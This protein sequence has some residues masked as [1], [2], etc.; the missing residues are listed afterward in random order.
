MS[1]G[2]SFARNQ[3]LDSVRLFCNLLVVVFHA[4]PFLYF[5]SHSS[6][7]W[8]VMKF[9]VYYLGNVFL[10][11][12]FLVSGWLYFRNFDI[13][14]Y[15]DKLKARVKRL[16]V[17]YV[18]WNVIMIGVYWGMS[19]LSARSQWRF[20][21]FHLDSGWDCLMAVLPVTSFS[22]DAPTWFIRTLLIFAV[23]SPVIYC[24]FKYCSGKVVWCMILLPLGWALW[25]HSTTW[26]GIKPYAISCFVMG[27]WIAYR[28]IDLCELVRKHR[29]VLIVVGLLAIAISFALGSWCHIRTDDG[30]YGIRDVEL[31]LAAPFLIALGPQIDNL[32]NHLPFKS[33]LRS[34]GFFV[35]CGHVFVVSCC[36][37]GMGALGVNPWLILPIASVASIAAMVLWWKVWHLVSPRSVR[38]VD[39]TL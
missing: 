4:Y 2:N 22:P 30:S 16:F 33:D 15:G 27:G 9:G 25:S 18:A 39:G 28:G 38:I 36:V 24:L 19:F 8:Y 14:K 12:L 23:L 10:P 26:G 6:I 20:A 37:H 34:S 1:K 7:D 11:T 13:T 32:V 35:Y 29:T 17:P 21:G 5:A 31:F 3:E